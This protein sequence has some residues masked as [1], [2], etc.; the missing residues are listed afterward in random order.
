MPYEIKPLPSG[1]YAVVKKSDGKVV[2]EHSSKQKA[3]R[4]IYAILK[5][6][7]KI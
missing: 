1:K 5:N 2:A 6:E 3:Q 4:Q 7:G